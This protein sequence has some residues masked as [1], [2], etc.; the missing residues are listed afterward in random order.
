MIEVVRGDAGQEHEVAHL[1]AGRRRVQLSGGERGY[2]FAQQRVH[3]IELTDILFPR[4]RIRRVWTAE[5][6]RSFEVER[7]LRLIDETPRCG[8]LP[9]GGVHH[10]LPDVVTLGPRPP[11][12]ESRADPPDRR[13]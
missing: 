4:A 5:P 13:T 8:V 12:G 2:G 1:L 6:V 9:V 10:R 3:P 11:H 7:T